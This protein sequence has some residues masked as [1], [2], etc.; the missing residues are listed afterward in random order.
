MMLSQDRP[1]EIG[2]MP[3]FDPSLKKAAAGLARCTDAANKHMIIISDGDPTPPSASTLKALKD[4]GV[5]VTTVAV[6]SHGILGS[7]EMRRIATFTGGKY[8]EVKNANALPKIYQREARRIARPLVFEP[9]PPVSPRITSQ[10]EMVQ[11]LEDAFPPISG[12]VLTSVKENSLVDVILTSPVPTESQNATVLATWTYGLGKTV[13][14]TTDAGQRWA[15]PG[16]AW[17]Q[18][19]QFFSQMVR[20]SMRPTGD[21]GKFAVSTD[22]EGGK[23]RVVVSAL[24]ND[25]EFLNYQAMSGTVLGPDMEPITLD[26]QQTGP[27]RYVGEFDSSKPGSYM[28]MVTPGPGQAMIRTGVN[29]GY[30]SEFRDRE[31]NTTLLEQI[32]ELPAKRGEA[33]KLMPPLPQL[34]EDREQAQKALGPQLAID[35]YR[36]DL[37]QA[38]A[39]QDIWPW[40]VLLAG[41][42]FFGDVFIRRVQV[43]FQ[44][45][46]PLWTR[47]AEKVL[48]REPH[49]EAPETMNRLR[50]RKA[51]IDRSMENRRAATRFE[52][53]GDRAIRSER[54][55][56]RR[57]QADAAG[58]D[59]RAA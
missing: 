37:P 21:T 24:D 4:G 35:P 5:T 6:G 19:D 20:W 58:D 50:S 48:G 22:V 38:V 29:V 16:P 57:S 15:T 18:Y 9:N 17:D 10:H 14:F 52:P 33:G 2:D 40:L 26:I 32:A 28:V 23:T 41:C 44:W 51:E 53:D 56:G 11:G 12:F 36:R 43:D 59:S 25:E 47:F 13:A 55:R 27:G 45:I 30:S 54:D 8:Y 3:D 31:T 7:R 1:H 34:P 42:L 39:S 49:A 46:A